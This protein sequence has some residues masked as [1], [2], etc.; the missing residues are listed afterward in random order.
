M[1]SKIILFLSDFR[2]GPAGTGPRK[3]KTYTCPGPKIKTVRG[4]RTNDAPVRY[5]LRAYPGI[6]EVICVVTRQAKRTALAHFK[7]V[8]RKAAPEAQIVEIPYEE[9][10]DFSQEAI[11]AI[12]E[13]IEAGDNIY[14]DITGGFRNANM[15]LL[16][17]SR[18]LSYKGVNI[19]GAVYSNF[20]TA[21]VEDVSHLFRLFDLVGGMQELTNLGSVRTL[22]RYYELES[23]AD[24]NAE[25]PSIMRLIDCMEKLTEDITL[26]HYGK[27]GQRMD[28]F[29]KAMGEAEDNCRDPLMRQLLGVFQDTFGQEMTAGSL[30][31]WC[32]G[33]DMIQQA[34][35][36]YTEYIPDEIM[37]GG[38]LSREP[39][40]AVVEK[41]GYQHQAA[42]QFLQGFLMLSDRPDANVDDDSPA[43]LCKK[44][45]NYLAT[46]ENR[47]TV[48]RMARNRVPV[49]PSEITAGVKNIALVARLAYP[50]DGNRF[51]PD[52]ANGLPPE[53]DG[54][55]KLKE[56]FKI[57]TPG[58]IRGFIRNVGTFG[59]D[60]L[61]VLLER[62]KQDGG[63]AK[64][65]SMLKGYVQKNDQDILLL[66]RRAKIAVGVENA[67]LVARL[68]YPHDDRFNEA[69]ADG[70]PPEKEGLRQLNVLFRGSRPA[71]IQSFVKRL[72]TLGLVQGCILLEVELP[73]E[74]NDYNSQITTLRNLSGLLPGSGYVAGCSVEQLVQ[75]SRDYLYIKALRNMANHA[76]DRPADN[77]EQLL[78]Y[79]RQSGYKPPEELSL[80]E[81]RDVVLDALDNLRKAKEGKKKE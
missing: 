53:K 15:H 47:Q 1:T 34:L 79:L 9:E 40:V 17:L 6:S 10:Q 39:G 20:G 62:E 49:I 75:V 78:D 19:A 22:R 12:L 28:E 32:V 41:Q 57:N 65:Y 33:N 43:G 80:A 50:G 3:P 76:N 69:W 48:V 2:K 64:L 16:L 4:S 14:L 67:A 29:N 7:Q 58:A 70:L 37:G 59:N 52:W 11:P 54:L 42:V 27:I 77:Q 21:T 66:A 71:T 26:C 24:P 8:V 55:R 74:N 72:T 68:A 81:I 36:V 23:A 18:V 45:R 61:D 5:L 56:R 30:V 51:N 63:S 38:I 25:D 31:R 13:R 46:D 60:Y 44:L 35:T 73:A